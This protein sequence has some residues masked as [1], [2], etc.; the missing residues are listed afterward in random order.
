MSDVLLRFVH[1]SDT[2]LSADDQVTHGRRPEHYSERVMALLQE[3][4]A[5]RGGESLA[6]PAVPASV[7]SKKMVA[8]INRLP[9]TPD[10]V[11]H[12]GDIM[13]DA[14]PDEYVHAKAILGEIQF[15]T[16][17]IPGNHDNAEGVQRILVR[18]SEIKP[19]YDYVREINGV[20]L[21]C[22]DDSTNG[23]DHGGKLSDDQLTWLDNICSADSDQPLIV[24][25]HHHIRPLGNRFINF[26]GTENGDAIHNAL[27]KAGRRLR[28]VFS[29]HIHQAVDI[30]DEGI[31]YSFVQSPQ[32]PTNLFPGLA[33]N[34]THQALPNPG[35]SIVTVT[36]DRTFVRR[37][38]FAVE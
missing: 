19:T 6:Q 24:A 9:F 18:E 34:V 5:L 26:F 28:G 29:G 37:F 14:D 11:I 17:Y 36:S 15:P 27:K 33:E 31:L 23:V 10:F 4:A 13:T 25:I 7:A 21:V 32:T 1:I 30:Y 35:F 22:V 3:A 2:H 8:E 38:N 16:F 20:Q 12:T